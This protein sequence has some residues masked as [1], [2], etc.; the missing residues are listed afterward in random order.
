M[1]F[2]YQ[3]AFVATLFL[4]LN[5][6]SIANEKNYLY[7][8]DIV[9]DGSN[10]TQRIDLPETFQSLMENND[11]RRIKIVDSNGN[12]IPSLVKAES[13]K[14]LEFLEYP[15][16]IF[17]VYGNKKATLMDA[18]NLKFSYDRGNIELNINANTS[19]DNETVNREQVP[20]AYILE[21][22]QYNE[23]NEAVNFDGNLYKLTFEWNEGFNGVA[24]MSVQTSDD[25]NNWLTLVQKD[26]IAHMSFLE[27]TLVKKEINFPGFAKR[28][29]KISWIG[30]NVQ[31]PVIHMV[32]GSWMQQAIMPANVWSNNLLLTPV[33]ATLENKKGNG[34]EIGEEVP[35][36]TFDFIVSPSYKADKFRL[37][38]NGKN[39]MFTG[40][41]K[42]RRSKSGS[43]HQ[44]SDFRF[45]H[46]ETEKGD[47]THLA[48]PI[49]PINNNFWRIT[50][51]YPNNISLSDINLQVTRYP[52][53]V[54]FIKEE[55][56][57]YKLVYDTSNA[58]NEEQKLSSMISEVLKLTDYK[59]GYAIL[60]NFE[61]IEPVIESE[62][63]N[64]KKIIIWIVFV[65]GI[66]L[67]LI[68]VRSLVR[69]MSSG[70][71]LSN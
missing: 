17:P 39:L 52:L 2:F 51:N 4:F 60:K 20:S 5:T 24:S 62:G 31:A 16:G 12:V 25:L 64:W 54:Y 21:N 29:L 34:G 33:K 68:M 10:T 49:N 70:N 36:N 26:S 8:A 19:A 38:A 55:N 22:P 32:S 56:K 67:M 61:F 48:K 41:I 45:Y 57:E 53:A 27:E 7:Q 15:L 40:S 11:L 66:L 23:S 65:S 3:V 28:Y 18:E 71:N 43:W 13:K 30:N 59:A 50:F 37:V 44:F 63:L 42:T 9:L 47:I 35:P 6:F 58:L 14:Q 1:K 46:I 69:D